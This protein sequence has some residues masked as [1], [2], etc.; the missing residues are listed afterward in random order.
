MNFV[1]GYEASVRGVTPSW[2]EN[3]RGG[4]IQNDQFMYQQLVY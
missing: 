3:M 2:K 1:I 4:F